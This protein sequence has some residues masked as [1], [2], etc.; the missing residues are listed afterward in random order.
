MSL[1]AHDGRRETPERVHAGVFPQELARESQQRVCRVT[2]A[3]RGIGEAIPRN[4]HG[5]DRS[6]TKR[7][8]R[9]R[10]VITGDPELSLQHLPRARCLI[11]YFVPAFVGQQRM[12]LSM[13][14]DC[15]TGT[16][17]LV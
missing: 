5:T 3:A 13:R 17:H 4:R 8:V 1:T 6:G 12:S 16:M 2:V 14:T 10:E 9:V 7:S 11:Q 15:H